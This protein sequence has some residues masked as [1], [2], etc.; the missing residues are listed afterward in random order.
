MGYN[1]FPSASK[2]PIQGAKGDR[3]IPTEM[4]IELC[5]NVWPRL[6]L[7][8]PTLIVIEPT[9]LISYYLLFHLFSIAWLCRFSVVFSNSFFSE[10]NSKHCLKAVMLHE[11]YYYKHRE[12]QRIVGLC[13]LTTKKLTVFLSDIICYVV[14]KV[15]YYNLITINEWKTRWAQMTLSIVVV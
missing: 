6:K 14:K 15:G 3:T 2:I 9:T 4:Y 10:F 7:Q 11:Q 12:K 1:F 8:N 13:F 5:F